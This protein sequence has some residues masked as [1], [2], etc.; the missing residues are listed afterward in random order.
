MHTQTLTMKKNKKELASTRKNRYIV[1][2]TI[3]ITNRTATTTI[4]IITTTTAIRS[5]IETARTIDPTINKNKITN[6]Y[7]N[8]INTEREIRKNPKAFN[9]KTCLNKNF[10]K[11]NKTAKD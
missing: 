11:K 9:T 1:T 5:A 10:I 6:F 7:N 8:N 3:T 4:I 2:T